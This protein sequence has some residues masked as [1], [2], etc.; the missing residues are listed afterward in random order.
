[1]NWKSRWIENCKEKPKYPEKICPSATLSTAS[2]TWPDLGSKP[3][4][5]GGNPVTNRL[6]Y[7]SAFELNLLTFSDISLPHSWSREL[8]CSN[9]LKQYTATTELITVIAAGYYFL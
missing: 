5:H 6:K 9:E 1:M 8:S 2:P 3:G 4:H 7:G